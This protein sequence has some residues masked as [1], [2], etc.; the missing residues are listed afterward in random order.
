MAVFTIDQKDGQLKPAR[1]PL[2]IST[3]V[4]IL[5]VPAE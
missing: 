1:Q 3:L 5:F 2:D 4:V